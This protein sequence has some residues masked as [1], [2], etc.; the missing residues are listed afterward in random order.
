MAQDRVMD[1]FQEPEIDLHGLTVDEA[2][3]RIDDFLYRA[4]LKKI[5]TVR[6]VHGKGTGALREAVRI[7]LPKNHIVKSFRPAGREY[8]GN[9]ATIVELV[10]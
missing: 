3:P 2:L 7:W 1:F 4:Y 9:G 5:T 10:D 8:G 6:I